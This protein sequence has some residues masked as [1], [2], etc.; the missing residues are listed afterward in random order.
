MKTPRLSSGVIALLFSI[1][2]LVST[3]HAD[4]YPRVT[5]VSPSPSLTNEFYLTAT[6]ITYNINGTNVK[7]LVYMDDPPGG[8]GVPA[9]IPG[10]L[11]ELTVGQ[12]AI[13]HFKNN[14][15]NNIEGASIHWH[16]IELDNDSDGTPITQDSVL[17]GQTYTYRFVA[18]RPGLCWYHSHMLPG[19]TTF[20]GMYGPI[21]IKN[22][23]EASLIASQ[24]LPSTNYTF[25]LVLSDI[26]FTNGVVGK[27]YNGTNY[28]LNTLIQLCEN[29]ILGHP[30]ADGGA[31]GAVGPPGSVALVNGKVPRLFFNFGGPCLFTLNT[32]ST[33][34]YHIGNHQRV[35]L[36]LF[37]AATSRDFY[38]SLGYPCTNPGGDTNLYHIGG[39]G[40]LLDNAVLDGGIQSGYDF[41]YNKGSIVIG[42]GMRSDVM[43]YSS[44]NN[45]DIIELYAKTLPSPPWKLT[46]GVPTSYPIA[47]FVITNGGSTNL[48]LAAGSPILSSLGSPK[49]LNENLQLLNTN[50]L[51]APPAPS[52]GTKNHT[53]LFQNS[54]PANG[55]VSG[56]TINGYAATALDG[57]TSYGSWL[58]IP[59]PPSSLWA[60]IG[61]VLQLAIV[62]E[63]DAMHPYHLH[64]FA[65]QPVSIRSANLATNL[66]T[67]PYRQFLDTIEVLP[68]QAV[69]FRIKLTDRPV[70]ADSATGGPVTVSSTAST[71]GSLGRWL[72]HCHIFLHAAV[73]MVSELNV[74]ANE[75]D[76]LVG[77]ASGSNSVLLAGSPG[78]AW[79]VTKSSSWL[80]LTPENSAGTNSDNIIFSFDANPGVTRFGSLNVAGKKVNITQ[81]GSNYVQAPGPVTTLAATGIAGPTGIAVDSAGNVVFADSGNGAIKRWNVANN[82]VSTLVSSALTTPQSLGL[83]RLGNIYF[84]DFY[85]TAIKKR[86]ATFPNFVFTAF[87]NDTTGVSGL[88]VDYSGNVYITIPSRNTVKK[89]DAASGVLSTLTTNG[90]HGPYGVAVD[91][92]DNVYVAD[93]L[94]DSVKRLSYFTFLGVPIYFWST[95]VASNYLNQPWNLAVDDGGN[96]YIA[97]GFNHAIKKWNA[98]SNTV[99]TL[100]SSGLSDPTGVAVD[101]ARNVYISDY[102]NGAIKEL[103]YA[104]VDPTPQ[105]EPAA[106]GSDTLAVILQ[107]DQNLRPPFAPTD[108]QPWL[109]ITSTN[110][111]VLSFN[112][113]ANL[114]TVPRTANISLLGQN[115]LVSQAAAVYPPFLTD[116]SVPTNGVFQFSF[117]NGTRG[118]IYSV[119]SSTNITVPLSNWIVIGVATNTSPNVW[120]FADVQAT[121]QTRFYTIRSP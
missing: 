73:G 113:T 72:M 120:Q 1:V 49:F 91:I 87:T 58:S 99:D 108:N 21:V 46:A 40:G 20:G 84:T 42:T 18:P 118:A 115:I 103:P 56:P 6:N 44:G 29:N 11:V 71:G 14:L 105:L 25:P 66:F 16:G 79:T 81:A 23:V 86:L 97:D 43:F 13:C 45:G 74:I 102:N 5:N 112:F 64:G 106:A 27:V 51:S 63:T 89:W 53:L 55:V 4:T 37:N 77:P 36:Q 110:G 92:A 117:T 101:S 7:V 52:Q 93:T 38:L 8:G 67:Y 65:M 85:S 50:A 57:N 90:L 96:I 82:T 94:N 107:P 15:T 35:R 2:M 95:V 47:F 109:T 98:A 32:S 75:S 30:N 70:Y 12:M 76:L 33:P 61:D 121:N 60:R 111:G 3:G 54:I 78:A 10:P 69:V 19:T 34:L 68:G 28:S 83:D 39:Q 88:A 31:C 114:N 9:A 62:N 48:P 116:A 41:L 119:L 24:V 17:P 59:H 104:F 22:S 80:H 26:S 100:V